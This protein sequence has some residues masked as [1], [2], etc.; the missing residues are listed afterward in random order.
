MKEAKSE[1]NEVRVSFP[2]Y[3]DEKSSTVSEQ[4][5]ASIEAS[6]IRVRSIRSDVISLEELG[7]KVEQL[8]KR[9]D[10][11]WDSVSYLPT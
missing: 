5:Q 4:K 1:L 2:M 6:E 8:E 9:L 11:M 7:S 10:C 3:D